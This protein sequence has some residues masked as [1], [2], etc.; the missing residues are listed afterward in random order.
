MTDAL[1]TDVVGIESGTLWL[2][3]AAGVVALVAGF[4]ALS[5]TKGGRR[6]RQAGKLFVGAMAVVVGSV[7]VLLALDP[8]PLRVFLALVAT[9]TGY[10]AFSGYRT[11]SRKRPVDGARAVDWAAVGL[12][13]V[14]CLALGGWGLGRVVG[15]DSFGVVLVV[16]GGIGLAFGVVD[17]RNFRLDEGGDEWMVTH[18]TRMLGALIA[19]VTAVSAVNLAMVPDLVAWLWPTAVGVPLIAHYANE[20]GEE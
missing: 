14:A 11:L 5:T 2:H 15:G 6:H 7:F 20:Y 4:T 18:L 8:T 10:L 16:F 12:V 3:V 13:L 19:T 17:A 9:F 1:E